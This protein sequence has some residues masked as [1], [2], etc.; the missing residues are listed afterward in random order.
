MRTRAVTAALAALLAFGTLPS[1]ALAASSLRPLEERDLRALVSLNDPQI[2]PDGAH[3]ALVVRRADFAK[4]RYDNTLVLV[5]THTGAARTLV[6]ERRDV[7]APRWSPRGDALAF[8]ATP[9]KDPDA[10]DEPQPQLYVLPMDGGEAARVTDSKTGVE[11][12]AW[13]PDGRAFA[14]IARDESPDKKRIEAHDDWFAITD[15]AWTSRAAPIPSHLWTVDADGK[16]TRRVTRG[17][18][19]LD[20]EPAF[21]PDGRS[22]YAVRTPSA[23]T[24]HYRARSLVAVDLAS[25]RVREIGHGVRG[26]DGI[27]IAPDHRHMLYGAEDPQAFSQTDLFTSALDGS[28]ARDVSAQLDRNVQLGLF[29]PNGDLITAAND[30]TRTRLFAISAGGAPRALPLGD[31]ELAGGASVA[32]D[33]TLAFVG[34]TPV[35]PAELYVLRVGANAPRKLTHYNDAVAAHALGA[36]YT[37][38]WHGAGGFVDDGVLTAP[39]NAAAGKRY[40]L[41]VL[42]HG[43]PTATSTLAF[44]G[45]VQL[46]A[47]RGWYV[48]QPNYRGSDNLGHRFA[49]ATVPYITSA[50]GR[51]VLDGVDAVEKLG[52]VDTARIGVSGWSEG[53]LLTSWLIGHDHRWRAAMSGAAVNDWI[54]YGDMTDAKDFTPSFIGPSPWTSAAMR[55]LYT[56]ESPLTYAS[57]VKT[58]TLIMTDAGDFRVPTPLAYE[59]YHAVRATGTPVE[60]VVIPV[61]GHNPSDPLHR[62]ER[63]HRWVDWF[64]THF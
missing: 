28:G 15:N 46:M 2:A 49:Q 6:G 54:G 18:W 25:A 16:H 26:G 37:I 60:M 52:I 34:A 21:A 59:F 62:E 39:V 32:H 22:V 57:D 45:L 56:N 4:N 47:A 38:T 51:D 24:N 55:A 8:V 9:P 17:T 42:I 23:S 1:A 36:T 11:L 10:K 5:D 41:M 53:G 61:N 12:Y 44:S 27:R 30:V 58:P 35:H 48:F 31:V 7:D 63:T 3:V 64:V 50:P 14:Y 19:S 33:G 20:G 29:A 13:R 43:G 40:P